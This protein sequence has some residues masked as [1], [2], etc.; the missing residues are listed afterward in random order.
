M[1]YHPQSKRLIDFSTGN[2]SSISLQLTMTIVF[3][4][5]FNIIKIESECTQ[6]KLSFTDKK[7][8]IKSLYIIGWNVLDAFLWSILVLTTSFTL[9]IIR[10]IHW[11]DH[12]I[13]F[14]ESIISNTLST[15]K[16]IWNFPLRPERKINLRQ[17][18][19]GPHFLSLN[20]VQISVGVSFGYRKNLEWNRRMRNVT[21]HDFRQV[22]LEPVKNAV[23]S[24]V[25]TFDWLF[26]R[27]YVFYQP[28]INTDNCF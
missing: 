23:L 24:P 19:F 8:S 22:Q 3:G 17:K 9:G 7:K 16:F 25:K 27:K 15:A 14:E 4:G 11:N 18:N 1:L 2:M 26:N 12:W 28:Q 10:I 5:V 6:R 20:C 21:I 13:I